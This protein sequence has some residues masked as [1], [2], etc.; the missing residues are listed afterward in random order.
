MDNGIMVVIAA[1][2]IITIV[3]GMLILRQFSK[4]EKKAL[5][6]KQQKEEY[7]RRLEEERTERADQ[8][9]INQT[10]ASVVEIENRE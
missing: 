1:V 6:A 2:F 7:I 3:F 4:F 8:T 9:D 10:D 5:H